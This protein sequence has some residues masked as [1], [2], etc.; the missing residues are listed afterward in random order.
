MVF[1][2]QFDRAKSDYDYICDLILLKLNRYLTF[3]NKK[4]KKLLKHRYR[5]ILFIEIKNNLI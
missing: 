2:A 1:K 4:N 3:I 5:V